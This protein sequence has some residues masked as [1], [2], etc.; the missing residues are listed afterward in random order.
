ML[1][2]VTPDDLTHYGMLPEFI[3]R[4]PVV[5]NVDPLTRE[6]LVQILTQPRNAIVKQFQQL[7]AMDNVE[8]TFTEDSLD[9][10][11]EMALKRETG[12]RGLRTIIERSLLDVM[13]ELPSR[14]DVRRCVIT[15]D[16]IRGVEGPELYDA[17]G[18][19]V[20]RL[21]KAA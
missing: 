17:S 10:T 19:Q 12:A 9:L 5:V 4:L 2:Q 1:R 13:Y 11:A 14:R 16:V 15:P 8:L 7:F 6:E 3:G 20:G 18:V 21:D